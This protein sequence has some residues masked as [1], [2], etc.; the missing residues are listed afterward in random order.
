MS[1]PSEYLPYLRIPG[2]F[3]PSLYH[4]IKKCLLVEADTG[5]DDGHLESFAFNEHLEERGG[6]MIRAIAIFAMF[7][8]V[9]FLPAAAAVASPAGCTRAELQSVVDRYIKAVKQGNPALM[10]LDP[11]LMPKQ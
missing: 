2:L 6:F 8:N 9:S 11:K 7:F 10:P 1:I 5:Q 4:Q 3:S